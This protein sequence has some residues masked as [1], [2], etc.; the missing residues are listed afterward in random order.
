L[1]AL[2]ANR[3]LML[4]DV[5]DYFADSHSETHTTTDADHGRLETRHH[6][7]CHD[8]DWLF[9]DRRYRGEPALPG[10]ATLAMVEAITERDG[11]TSTLRRYYVSSATS[12]PHASP[13]RCAPIGASQDHSCGRR[14]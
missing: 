8:V 3:P 7:V 1:F 11:R 2:K 13:R 12:A 6:V 14:R 10:L 5:A 9:S 4:G